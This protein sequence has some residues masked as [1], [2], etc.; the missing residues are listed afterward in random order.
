MSAGLR[1]RRNSILVFMLIVGIGLAS[2]V[3]RTPAIRDAA[4]AST[5]QMGLIL[6]GLSIGSMTGV[7]ASGA[8]VARRGTRPVILLGATLVLV[9]TVVIALAAGAGSGP[10]VFAGLLLFGLGCGTGEIALNVEGAQIEAIQGKPLLPLLHGFFSLGTVVGALIGIA[11]TAAQFSV[12]WHLLGVTAL[13][14][15][16]GLWAAPGVPDGVGLAPPR[17]STSRNETSGP[18]PWRDPAVLLIGAIVL[19][20]AFAEGT[21][22]DWLP[23]LM[24]DAHGLSEVYGSLLYAGFAAMMALGR[25]LGGPIVQRLGR[26]IVLGG[27]AVMAIAGILLVSYAPNLAVAG[28]AVVLWG[29]GASLG[30]PVAISAAGDSTDR[31]AQRVSAV[32]ASGYLAFLV[33]PPLLGYLGEHIGLQQAMLV[34]AALLIA[35]SVAT[36]FVRSSAEPAP[37][38]AH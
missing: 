10:A 12:L 36:R 30:F 16:L 26:G 27:S 31:P 29:L 1:R 6:F 5:A 13:L 37:A 21:A 24:V 4:G 22:N 2:W 28:V 35:A 3:T 15:I 25:F 23:L 7:L 38:Q 8:L 11:L 9:G 14:I 34:P 33:G 18:S 32:A 17:S 20:M 19:A